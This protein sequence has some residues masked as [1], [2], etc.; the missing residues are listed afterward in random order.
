MPSSMKAINDSIS[1]I[2]DDWG[3][4]I[5]EAV[6][7][8]PKLKDETGVNLL[9]FKYK[10]GD[11]IHSDSL[12]FG[13][14]VEESFSLTMFTVQF[15]FIAD[16]EVVD[17]SEKIVTDLSGASSRTQYASVDIP[18]NLPEF[19]SIDVDIKTI[20]NYYDQQEDYSEEED[21]DA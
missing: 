5:S 6:A 3:K 2:I 1:K 7:V 20:S 12:I 19:E 16:N 14:T 8:D 10:K 18:D 21:Q 17:I 4:S 15:R 13:F 11:S 9:S